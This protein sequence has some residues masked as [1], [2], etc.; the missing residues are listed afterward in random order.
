M[1]SFRR[2]ETKLAGPR[3]VANKSSKGASLEAIRMALAIESKAVRR[4]TQTFNRARYQAT[5]E[6]EDY[7]ALKDRARAIKEHAIENLPA[8]LRQL[9]KSV[10]ARG[11]D[12]Y[13]AKD[14]TDASQYVLRVCQNHRALLVAKSK[15]ITSE[16]IK[17]NHVLETEGI[18]VAETDLAELILQV[19]NG[20][21]RMRQD[22]SLREALYC[23]RCS[24]CLNSCANFQAVGGHPFGGETYSG[25]IGGS[26]E[27]GTGKLEN[28]R[29]SELCTGCSRCVRECP[30]R[31]KIPWLNIVLRHRL[32]Q[33]EAKESFSVVHEGL[34]PTVALDERAPLQKWFFGN[35]RFFGKW[36]SRLAPLSNWVNRL[37][38]SRI[39]LER[40]V[41][42]DRRRGIPSF[43]SKPL[44]ELYRE[45]QKPWARGSRAAQGA[46]PRGKTLVFANT[47][48]DYGHS[49]G[50]SR[51][52]RF[53]RPSV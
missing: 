40:L 15:S 20:R 50:E 19:D 9:E 48:T 45:W 51:Q 32:N 30:V 47:F 34:M 5:A 1:T 22:S 38:L 49:R 35:C 23:I 46:Y 8:L 43:P 29:F 6:I 25:G 21:L 10:T 44:T 53:W 3:E 14:P 11:G 4:N 42:R 18:E 7:E 37:G 26:W 28:A 17:L 13:L 2:H 12:S 52:S 27:P 31:I 39:L 33:I 41:G 24:T 16:E 36:G